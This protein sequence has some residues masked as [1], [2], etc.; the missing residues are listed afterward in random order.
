MA[1]AQ[2]GPPRLDSV[3]AQLYHA[4]QVD[5]EAAW[6]AVI[7]Y[8]PEASTY[9]RYLAK[10]GLAYYYLHS[11]EYEKAIEPL[12][13]LAAQP[14]FQAFGIAGLVVVYTNLG[15]DEKANDA[16]QRLS[17]EMRTSLS[18]QS[19]QMYELLNKSLDELADRARDQLF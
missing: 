19:P 5:T 1:G 4:K 9:C 18:K 6:Q 12:E 10:Q 14:D 17:T 8:F 15:E 7:S 13:E 3:W 2:S 11:H 16:N